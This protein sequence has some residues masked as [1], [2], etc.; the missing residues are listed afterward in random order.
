MMLLMRS[1]KQHL[2]LVMNSEGALLQTSVELLYMFLTGDG[3][4]C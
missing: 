4:C 2:K 3:A 1:K